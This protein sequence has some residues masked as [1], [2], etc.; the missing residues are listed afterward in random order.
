[1]L[2]VAIAPAL[3]VRAEADRRRGAGKRLHPKPV[4]EAVA[5]ARGTAGRAGGE[6]LLIQGVAPPLGRR[7]Q[8]AAAAPPPAA[9]L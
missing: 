3:S 7:N 6:S 1:L 2:P 4:S 8:A 9:H 5:A